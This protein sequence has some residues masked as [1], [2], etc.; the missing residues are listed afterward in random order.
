[1]NWLNTARFERDLLHLSLASPLWIDHENQFLIATINLP[2]G[3]NRSS[4]ELLLQIPADYPLSPP[5]V[6]GNRIF[7]HP[8]LRFRGNKLADLHESR[9][10]DF[11]TPGHG[12]WAWLCY[13]EIRWD[14]ER[15]DLVKFVEMVRADLTQPKVKQAVKAS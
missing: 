11:A 13:E 4:T 1:M 14:P 15:D 10:P 7:V 12:P 3:F 5:G 8:D 6:G 9:S 2:P